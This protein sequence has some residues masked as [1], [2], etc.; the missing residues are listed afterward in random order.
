MADDSEG[1]Q[2][3]ANV[4]LFA[5]L[6]RPELQEV[7]RLFDEE[8]FEQDRRVLRRGIGGSN[9]HVIVEGEAAVRVDDHEL[10]RLSAGGF[11][12][13]MTLLLGEPPSADVI[14]ITPL[15]CRVLSGDQFESFLIEHPRVM[16]RMLQAQAHRHKVPERWTD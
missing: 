1:I 7:N 5:D 13:E 16:Y 4:V 11:F 9:F 8:F 3:L 2:E 12:G 6:T 15:R 14:A 10:E